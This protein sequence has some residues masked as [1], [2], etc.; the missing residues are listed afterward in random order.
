M[1]RWI[2]FIPPRHTASAEQRG[3]F[4]IRRVHGTAAERIAHTEKGVAGNLGIKDL[5][6][7]AE[8]LE[9]AIRD[10]HEA[11]P[12]LLRDFTAILR[13]QIQN[14]ERALG[15]SVMSTSENVAKKNLDSVA[16][17]IGV[18]RLR[19]LLEAS[20]GDAEEAFRTLQSVLSGHV[21]KVRLDALGTSIDDFDFSGALLKLDEIAQ[22]LRL[23][24][25]T[26]G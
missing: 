24:H 7:A 13:P 15:D 23:S 1:W 19:V 3:L 22:E 8:R 4:F 5:R 14:I 9:K 18:V 12:S 25:G 2:T 6:F 11:A 20:D 17:S 26:A 16:A 21:E 10:G